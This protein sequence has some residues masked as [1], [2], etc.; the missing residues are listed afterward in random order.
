MAPLQRD[1]DK[2]E[3]D[4][5]YRRMYNDHYRAI[6]AYC[7]RRVSSADAQDAA[8]EVFTIA[9]RR[10]DEVPGD[11]K[12]LPGT[13]GETPLQPSPWL[14]TTYIPGTCT[15]VTTCIDLLPITPAGH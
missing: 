5:H 9:W 1:S 12:V 8:A 3:T 7:R 13:S 4:A 14:L 11:D 15:R 10:L 2:P 6:L